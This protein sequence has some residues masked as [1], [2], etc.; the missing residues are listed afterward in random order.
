[1]ILIEEE[2]LKALIRQAVLS[3]VDEAIKRLTEKEFLTTAE[4]AKVFSVSTHTLIAWRQRRLLPFIKISGRVLFKRSELLAFLASH[5]V[6][7]RSVN[8]DGA[9]RDTHEVPH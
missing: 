4:A 3:S 1:M 8:N 2:Q 7:G 6:K 9:A 5:H